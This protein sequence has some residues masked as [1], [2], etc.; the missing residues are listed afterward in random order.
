MCSLCNLCWRPIC[1]FTFCICFCFER[2]KWKI[3]VNSLPV[4][5]PS[6]A[7]E[8]RYLPWIAPALNSCISRCTYFLVAF[9]NEWKCTATGNSFLIMCEIFY[10]AATVLTIFRVLNLN[11]HFWVYSFQAIRG[12]YVL[13]PFHNNTRYSVHQSSVELILDVPRTELNITIIPPALSELL[14]EL[15]DKYGFMLTIPLT[16][17]PHL[18]MEDN[19]WIAENKSQAT[20][21]FWDAIIELIAFSIAWL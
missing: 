5:L 11:D 9:I 3:R 12:E 4:S 19:E 10:R 8:V 1:V 15:S 21:K 16:K 18:S 17:I 6:I 13:I 7:N 2:D 14:S 20:G